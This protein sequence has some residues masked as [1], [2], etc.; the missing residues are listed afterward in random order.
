MDRIG[1]GRLNG[2]DLPILF[3]PILFL[4]NRDCLLIG[5]CQLVVR[6]SLR[7]QT[8]DRIHHVGLLRQKRIAELLRPIELT[9]HHREHGRRCNQ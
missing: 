1:I 9:A 5:R 6:L 3:L 2:N 8:L 4:P 7:A